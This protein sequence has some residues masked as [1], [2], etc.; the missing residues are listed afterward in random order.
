MLSPPPLS[1][2]LQRPRLPLLIFPY[3]PLP[4]LVKTLTCH[5]HSRS[6]SRVRSLVLMINSSA[7]FLSPCC[8]EDSTKLQHHLLLLVDLSSR[9]CWRE[10]TWT[11]N[12][13]NPSFSSISFSRAITAS[14][15]FSSLDKLLP[16]S[17]MVF[18]RTYLQLR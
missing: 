13:R 7:T 3:L 17:G 6:P 8:Y 15:G 10:A 2:L 4:H 16:P 12:G 11:A 9:L 5:P 18:W 1:S 14:R